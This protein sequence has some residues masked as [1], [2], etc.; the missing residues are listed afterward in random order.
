MHHWSLL[1]FG[2]CFIELTYFDSVLYN[3]HAKIS[4]LKDKKCCCGRFLLNWRGSS[5]LGEGVRGNVATE[6]CLS[7]GILPWKIFKLEQKRDFRHSE[8]K[9]ACFN[10]FFFF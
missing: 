7:G 10:I 5:F 1:L 3:L 9:S 2:F 8:A 4:M 6:G